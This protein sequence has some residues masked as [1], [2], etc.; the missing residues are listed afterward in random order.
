MI[1]GLSHAPLQCQ[2]FFQLRARLLQPLPEQITHHRTRRFAL[3]T[4]ANDFLDLGQG[5]AEALCGANE[6]QPLQFCCGEQLISAGAAGA[7]AQQATSETVAHDV[8]RHPCLL[9]E[10]SHRER[11]TLF[12]EE[13]TMFS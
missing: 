8:H 2:Q 3:P 13:I 9:R 7:G 12:V 4:A 11:G 10:A 6:L 5:E 1:N